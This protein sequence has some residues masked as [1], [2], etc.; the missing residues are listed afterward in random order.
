MD[1]QEDHRKVFEKKEV[2]N[3]MKDDLVYFDVEEITNELWPQVVDRSIFMDEVAVKRKNEDLIYIVVGRVSSELW[4]Q[5]VDRNM[6][7][8]L[9][10]NRNKLNEYDSLY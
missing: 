6:S 7:C 4:P 1:T 3:Y 8:K 5:E 9:S 2:V 10:F